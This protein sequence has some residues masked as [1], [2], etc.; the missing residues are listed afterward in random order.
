MWSCS[1]G[2][3]YENESVPYKALDGV[4]DDLSR[5]LASI[6]RSARRE[7]AAARS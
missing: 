1:S 2:R 5:Y 3:C 4:I 6:P 7:P